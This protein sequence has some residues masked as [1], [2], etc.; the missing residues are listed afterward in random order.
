[1]LGWAGLGAG[2]AWADLDTP[3]QVVREDGDGV[4]I[5]FNEKLLDLVRA[6]QDAVNRLKGLLQQ[7]ASDVVESAV[8]PTAPW[9]SD[10][11]A[12]RGRSGEVK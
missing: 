3:K 6:T 4:Q 2:L 8:A 12:D 5:S 11:V 7:L 9:R 1:M 10:A